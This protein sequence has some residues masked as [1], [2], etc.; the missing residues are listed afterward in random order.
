LRKILVIAVREYAA[1]VKTK[2]FIFTLILL[3]LWMSAG[4]LMEKVTKR[5][6]DVSEKRIAVIDRT[7]AGL[8]DIL[9]DAA[10]ERN[11]KNIFDPQTHR[12]TDPRATPTRK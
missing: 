10:R 4:P 7:G 9:E 6:G 1:A 3:P 12:Q 5:A 11:E 8:Y 2:A